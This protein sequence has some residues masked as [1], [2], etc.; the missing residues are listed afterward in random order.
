MKITRDNYE[1]WFLD[2]LEERLDQEQRESVR[3]FINANPDLAEELDSFA[4]ALTSDSSLI[5]PDK[6]RL[7]RSIFDDATHLEN[8][9]IAAMEGD[10]SESDRQKLDHWLSTNPEAQHMASLQFKCRL[11]PDPGINFLHKERLKKKVVSTAYFTRIAAVAAILLL[12]MIIFYPSDN[13]KEPVMVTSAG[14]SV[15]PPEEPIKSSSMVSGSKDSQVALNSVTAEKSIPSSVRQNRPRQKTAVLVPPPE[16][17][18]LA[19]LPL[20]PK[21]DEVALE[22]PLN[23]ELVPLKRADQSLLANIEM[24]ISDY[25]KGRA[26]E[27]KARDD[28]ELLSRNKMVIAGLNFVSKLTGKKLTGKKGDDG[29]LRTISFNTQLLAFSIPVNRQL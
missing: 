27:L 13:G 18:A 15:K 5:F 28:H 8:Q 21:L 23:G 3:Q 1:S 24:P 10:L 29:R 22:L 19:L 17:Q 20:K 14:S 7:K 9:V 11:Q 26:K 4:P 25:L 16:R 2:Y 6:E 12:A